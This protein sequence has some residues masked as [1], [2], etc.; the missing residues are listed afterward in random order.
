MI[1]CAPYGC[2]INNVLYFLFSNYANNPLLCYIILPIQCKRFRDFIKSCSDTT[3]RV[4]TIVFPLWGCEAKCHAIPALYYLIWNYMIREFQ[5]LSGLWVS[6]KKLRV[7]AKKC[8]I[9]EKV[10]KEGAGL[11]KTGQ[12][13]PIWGG[14]GGGT[15]P[16]WRGSPSH[17]GLPPHTKNFDSPPWALLSPLWQK[18]FCA[19]RVRFHYFNTLSLWIGVYLTDLMTNL[20]HYCVG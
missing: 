7:V 10:Q 6:Y 3:Y 2:N 5:G 9:V 18:N 16:T 15:P 8:Q 12:G 14:W 13:C 20:L 4:V 19:L 11:H 1:K 17:Q